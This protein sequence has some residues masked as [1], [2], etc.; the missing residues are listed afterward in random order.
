ML[1]TQNF[2]YGGGGLRSQEGIPSLHSLQN[3]RFSVR[4]V[5]DSLKALQGEMHSNL[6]AE[7]GPA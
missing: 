1:E 7:L 2:A 5:Q 6:A 4:V 3:L